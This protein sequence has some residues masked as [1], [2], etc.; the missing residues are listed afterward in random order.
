MKDV[1]FQW[2]FVALHRSMCTVCG[3]KGEE[4]IIESGLFKYDVE[5]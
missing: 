5:K 3:G 4:F 2:I 1:L